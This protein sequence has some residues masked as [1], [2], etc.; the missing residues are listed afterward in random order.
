VFQLRYLIIVFLFGWKGC[1]PADMK[2]LL[3]LANAINVKNNSTPEEKGE[4]VGPAQA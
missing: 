3:D 2:G 1:K 4:T